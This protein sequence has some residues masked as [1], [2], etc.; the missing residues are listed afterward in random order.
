MRVVLGQHE[1]FETEIVN[2]FHP[3]IQLHPRER[4]EVAG[5]L[6]ARLVEMVLIQVQVAESVNEFAGAKVAH[7]R[8]H[9]GKERVGG[10][11][12]GNAEKQVGTALIKLAAQ[13]ALTDVKLEEHMA[14]RKRHA[15]ELSDIP[16]AHDQAPA[17]RVS[18][19]L[20]DDVVDLIDDSA[21]RA[22]PANPLRAVNRNEFSRFLVGPLVPDRHPF[23]VQRPHIRVA[24]Q[25][26]EQL[27]D[28]RLEMK[29]LCGE[30]RESFA[31]IE[32][33]LR[34]ENRE[35]PGARPIRARSALFEHKAKKIVVFAHAGS[36][37]RGNEMD[38]IPHF[39]FGPSNAITLELRRYRSMATALD[40][41]PSPLPQG[42]GVPSPLGR[43]SG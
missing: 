18:F 42:E 2:A 7:L 43:R 15:V 9:H 25:E 6:L 12:E 3:G 24:L 32:T 19:Y 8:H 22:A 39:I 34:A 11:V 5:E 16:G 21:V 27:V 4:S 40:P 14:G 1:I 17:L 13:L 41:H 10:D 36:D 30:K 31:Q 23:F 26:P 38:S 29:F 20:G 35:R 28:D 37:K 33:S